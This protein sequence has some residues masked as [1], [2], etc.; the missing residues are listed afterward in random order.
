[1]NT[2][3]SVSI[4]EQMNALEIKINEKEQAHLSLM[5]LAIPMFGLALLL[6]IG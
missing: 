2:N 5:E 6:N 4:T 3:K 1:M